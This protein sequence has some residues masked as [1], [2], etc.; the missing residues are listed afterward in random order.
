MKYVAVDLWSRM[1]DLSEMDL[2]PCT[3]YRPVTCVTNDFTRYVSMQSYIVSHTR[4]VLYAPMRGL[5]RSCNVPA[6]FSVQYLIV[7]HWFIGSIG[8]D[9]I[10]VRLVVRVGSCLATVLNVEFW[11][12]VC[13]ECSV[14]AFA[15]LFI[16]HTSLLLREEDDRRFGHWRYSKVYTG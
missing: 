10:Y 8:V 6:V 13:V 3:L 1:T 15:T 16:R 2:E 4:M 9:A 14:R 11:C 7:Y 12:E 5:D